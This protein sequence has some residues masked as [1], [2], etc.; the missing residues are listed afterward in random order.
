M[1]LNIF[2]TISNRCH[3]GSS[4][5]HVLLALAFSAVLTTI[6]F[7]RHGD[8]I[9]STP[10]SPSSTPLDLP[11]DVTIAS[12][13][14]SV[15]SWAFARQKVLP[16]IDLAVEQLNVE[17]D[18]VIRFKAVNDEGSCDKN[19]VGVAAARISCQHNISIFI[20]PGK[21]ADVLSVKLSITCSRAVEIVAYMANDWNV[22]IITPVGNTENIGDKSVFPRLT[23]IN[24]T[25]QSSIVDVVFYLLRKYGWRHAVFFYDIEET[26][27]D[28]FGETFT[29]AF[30][31]TTEYIWSGYKLS[32]K[33]D[34]RAMF[35]IWLMDA[36]SRSRV[37]IMC[38]TGPVLGN[39]MLEAHSLGYATSPEFV[40][41]IM[42]NIVTEATDDN[43]WLLGNGTE[44]QQ[45]LKESFAQA[46]FM[47]IDITQLNLPASFADEMRRR[48]L[49]YYGY[50]YSNDEP[51]I[52][53]S[54]YYDAVRMYATVL[55]ESI[56]EGG[57]PYDGLGIT[58]RL[59]N[60]T[61]SGLIGPVTVNKD[62]DRY[63]DVTITALNP[64]VGKFQTY[65]VYD[66]QRRTL[67][68]SKSASSFP[69][70]LN[71]GVSPGDE[72][73]CGYIG[74]LCSYSEK[75][76]VIG[77]LAGFFGVA[78][79]V[80]GFVSL[81]MFRRWKKQSERDLW[82]WK[83]DPTDVF[84][85]DRKFTHSIWS[86]TSKT[87]LSGSRADHEDVGASYGL[88]AVFRGQLVRLRPIPIRHLKKTT[89][90]LLT[91]FKLMR[92][93][94][95]NNLLR[96]FGACLEESIHA[97]VV[98][99]CS[100]GSLQDL[101]G[102]I[103]VTLDAQFKFSLCTDII[104]GLCYLHK[105]PVRCHGRLNSEVCLVDNR[106]SVKLADFGLPSL[107]CSFFEDVTSQQYKHA[108]LWKA[109]EILRSGDRRGQPEADIYSFAIIMSEVITRDFPFSNEILY[110][111][112][113]EI[114]EKVRHVSD[115][116]FRPVVDVPV[117]MV[118][119]KTLMEKCWEENPRERPN[120]QTVKMF[121]RRIATSLG[122]TGNLLDNL[123]RRM[124]LYAN[125]LEKLVE[126]KTVELREEK[127]KSEELLYQILPRY[128]S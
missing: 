71:N 75:S 55:N 3:C 118:E 69:W 14:P 125:N 111:T 12:L 79:A 126:D 56:S 34:T 87:N 30:K 1:K 21:L 16:A 83:I 117:K 86:F 48:S 68:F 43:T 108:C 101:L 119:M 50:N 85:T 100:K 93:L 97:L 107:Y 45:M 116:P 115:S 47:H 41:V 122:E 74:V 28:L 59:W 89:D 91:E 35:R 26:M 124:E 25:M 72:P 99:H 128:S 53:L 80:G 121:I 61:F 73:A 19:V 81:I 2:N 49:V 40:F 54:Q 63:S 114:L 23:R 92:D 37:F 82:W 64:E 67:T 113:E 22:P 103:N 105:S 98:E 9:H 11:I 109:P 110:L 8:A 13:E 65:A 77:G 60:R 18:G 96:M 57:N 104:N 5:S 62:G 51:T 20:G 58:R 36:A 70:P 10:A 76:Q 102:N 52:T 29:K 112:I 95:H 66:S 123:M 27:G 38:L 120:A 15:A 24:P 78:V 44:E 7:V 90:Q 42:I 84:I 33:T 94:C 46:L 88:L 106:F 17:H 32:G 39:F 127:K 4:T 6:Y 31:S